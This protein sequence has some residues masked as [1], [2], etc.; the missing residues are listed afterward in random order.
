MLKYKWAAYWR[1]MGPALVVAFWR[2]LQEHHGRVSA[3]L[4][5]TPEVVAVVPSTRQGLPTPLFRVV[6]ALED[7]RPLLHPAVTFRGGYEFSEDRRRAELTPD[8][9]DADDSVL[10]GRRVL[11]V[12][13][14]WVSGARAL[15][16]AIAVRRASPRSLALVSIARMVYPDAMTPEYEQAADRPVDFGRWPR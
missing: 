1:E 3:A 14:T 7:L 2:W 9:F 5:G 12:E 13:D 16:A 10:S 15:S 6:A 4:D 11:L 8:A